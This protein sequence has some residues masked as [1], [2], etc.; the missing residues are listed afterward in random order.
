MYYC[1]LQTP[2]GKLLLA[3][4]AQGLRH[5]DF[6][7]GP[8]PAK[9][10]ADWQKDEKPFR[11]VIKQLKEYFAGQRRSFDLPL[12]P[13]GTDFQLKVWRALRGIPFGAT[14]SYGQLAKRIGKPKASRAVGAANGQNPL[15]I[16]VPCHRVIGANGSLTG[17]GGGLKIKQQLLEL[18]SGERRLL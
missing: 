4:D 17:F 2:V 7:D 16:I 8:H 15:P 18:E 12:A 14:W 10:Q 3:G 13:E 5:V 9:P 11:E 1:Y 6:Q